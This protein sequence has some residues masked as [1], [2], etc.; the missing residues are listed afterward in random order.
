MALV[1]E[2]HEV[3]ERLE[4]LKIA[5]SEV[6]RGFSYLYALCS[7]K[8]GDIEDIDRNLIR[9]LRKFKGLYSVIRIDLGVVVAVDDAGIGGVKVPDPLEDIFRTPVGKIPCELL[10]D[11]EIR[12]DDEKIAVLLDLVQVVD[13]RTHEA[14]LADAGGESEAVGR[15]I[16]MKIREPLRDLPDD[17]ETLRDGRA[18]VRPHD[19]IRERLQCLP[20]GSTERHTSS[21]RMEP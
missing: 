11:R 5:L 10:I 16:K 2:Y 21:G 20:L 13:H 9:K 18:R 8:L 19:S 4:I 17:P 14:G 7:T 6:L 3:A 15:E 12:S 1:H